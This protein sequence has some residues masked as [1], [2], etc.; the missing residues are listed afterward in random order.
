MDLAEK[1]ALPDH[2]AFIKGDL[3]DLTVDSGP[4][5]NGVV[6]LDLA[7]ALENDGKVRALDR[8]HGDRVAAGPVV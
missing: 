5:E 1:I 6:G 3:H 7:D 2:S 4:D 8:R